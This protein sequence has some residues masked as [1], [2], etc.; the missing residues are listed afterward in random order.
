MGN[1]DRKK[2]IARWAILTYSIGRERAHAMT[3]EK[4][5][6]I[7]VVDDAPENVILLTRI[8]EN[9]GYGVVSASQ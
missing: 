7:L 9:A 8:L 3:V 2:M 6:T 5:E 1:R 4:Q